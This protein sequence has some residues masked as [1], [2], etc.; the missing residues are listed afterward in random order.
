MSEE[1]P[2]VSVLLNLTGKTVIVT[3]ASG[4]IGAGIARRLAESGAHVA[5][6]YCTE[7]GAAQAVVDELT[8][9]GNRAVSFGGDLSIRGAAETLM[10]AVVSEFGAVDGLVNNGGIQPVVP[11]LGV[12]HEAL[13]TML[14]TNVSGPFAMIQ[15][16]ARHQNERGRPGGSVVNI[17]S[18]EGLQ[19]ATGHSHYASSKAALIMLTRAAAVELGPDKIRVNAVCPGLVHRQGLETDWPDGVARYLRAAPLGRLGEAQ[20]VADAVLFLLSNAARWITG[21]TLVVDG[22][23]SCRSTW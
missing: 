14:S 20:D 5:V 23:V 12:T 15:A 2:A 7:R 3:G 4:N 18:I 16:F 11:L 22:G 17:A 8:A 1:A 6:H 10:S 21:T 9:A 19:P 13:S